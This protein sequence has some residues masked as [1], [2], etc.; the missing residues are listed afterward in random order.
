MA[1]SGQVVILR[2]LTRIRIGVNE[3]IEAE[4]SEIANDVLT[5]SRD[6]CPQLTGRLIRSAGIDS[7]DREDIFVR[8]VFYDTPY[9]VIQHEGVFNPG[10]VTAS[11]PGAGR[12]YLQRAYEALLPEMQLRISKRTEL[13]L[14]QL[15]R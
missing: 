11:K 3:A 9:A 4:L 15:L 7:A 12:K 5:N 6:I 1:V 2:N 10:P 8:S 14:T 13:A